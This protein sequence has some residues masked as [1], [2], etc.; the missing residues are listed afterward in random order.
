MSC[1]IIDPAELTPARLDGIL[2]A[3]G[4]LH[5]ARVAGV[6]LRTQHRGPFS[7][8]AF[9]DVAYA[10]K[11]PAAAPTRLFLKLPLP[12]VEVSRQ[13][14]REE[15]RFYQAHGDDARLP[16]VRCFDAVHDGD[17]GGAHLL[18]E[19]LSE[20]HST[21]PPPLPPSLP[22]AQSMIDALLRFHLRWWESPEL[23]V[24]VGERWSAETARRAV[25]LAEQSYG[26][27]CDLVGDL[28]SP[29]RRRVYESVLESWPRLLSR[30]VDQPNLTLIHGDA[31][32]WN[33]L[34]PND[35]RRHPA[36]LVDLGTSRIRPPTNDLAYFMALMWFPDV[37]ERWERPLLERYHRG[38]LEAGVE[39]Y[40]RESFQWDYRFAV[41]VHLFTPVFQACGG[42]VGPSTWWYSIERITAAFHDLG[43]AELLDRP[44]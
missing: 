8:R 10:G 18:L 38:L 3:S 40:S 16:L 27:F 37:R 42:I 28:W 21:P 36:Y 7:V 13:M 5:G 25:E 26:R 33:C 9:Y 32:G 6:A 43:C 14:L 41:I 30:L 17:D 23:G 31:H 39:G 34:L 15:V 22:H 4:L 19:D 2:G 44:A 29:R 1:A 20:T 24:S 35:P 11:P 12:G